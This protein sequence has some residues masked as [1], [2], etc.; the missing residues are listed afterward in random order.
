[1]LRF[2][3]YLVFFLG[4]SWALLIL[5]NSGKYHATCHM[6]MT[7]HDWLGQIVLPGRMVFAKIS[8]N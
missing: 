2:W 5:A 1:M 7:G 3:F 6:D 8:L 4:N